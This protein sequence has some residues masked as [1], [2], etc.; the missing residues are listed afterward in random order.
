MQP[1]K[2]LSNAINIPLYLFFIFL[3]LFF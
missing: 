1:E 3:L 2:V